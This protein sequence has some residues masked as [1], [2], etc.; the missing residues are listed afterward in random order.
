MRT[1]RSF[2]LKLKCG[3]ASLET[4]FVGKTPMVKWSDMAVLGDGLDGEAVPRF[5]HEAGC[6][7]S[8]VVSWTE[9]F[10]C[11]VCFTTSHNPN[12]VEQG[13]CGNCHEFTRKDPPV[14]PILRRQ[15]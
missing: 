13:Y 14:L 2:H 5:C 15:D 9:V 6:G 4:N 1:E 11:P 10:I 12:D 8:E 3:H 7:F